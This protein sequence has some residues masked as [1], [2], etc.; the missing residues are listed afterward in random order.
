MAQ[1]EVIVKQLESELELAVHLQVPGC[2]EGL[3]HLALHPL[4]WLAKL[5]Q[6]S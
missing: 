1:F 5:N 3:E 6:T 2:S 4:A